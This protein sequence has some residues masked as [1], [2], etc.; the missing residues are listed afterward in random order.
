[1]QAA[2]NT[3]LSIPQSESGFITNAAVMGIL[4]V[5]AGTNVDVF[6]K[7]YT[8]TKASGTVV[9]PDTYGSYNFTTSKQANKPSDSLTG[10]WSIDSLQACRK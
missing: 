2:K 3:S 9:Y 4:D 5:P 8:D 1:M 7:V 10:E 6:I